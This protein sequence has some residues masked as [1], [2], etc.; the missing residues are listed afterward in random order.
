[1]SPIPRYPS[2]SALT[3]PA[4][5]GVRHLAS[6]QPSSEKSPFCRRASK[7]TPGWLPVARRASPRSVF[8]FFVF[9]LFVFLPASVF[10]Q[11]AQ[12]ASI[13]PT[14]LAPG[15]QVTLTGS[16]FGA[17]QES[18][19]VELQNLDRVPV[20]SWS[21]T[22]IVV[23]VP[24]GT[25]SGGV[26]VSQNGT[27]SNGLPFSMIPAKLAAISPANLA[28]G[29]LAT[30]TGSGFGAAQGSGFVELQNLDRVPVVT[31]SDTRIA[32]TVP[33]GT[34]SGKAYV[35]QNGTW[36]N[37]IFFAMIPANITS[38]S[39][40]TL[41]PGSQATLTGSGFGSAQESGF[42]E[43]QNLDRVPVISWSDTR[44]VVTVPAG[45]ISGRAFVNQD[46]T[47]SNGA[48]FTIDDATSGTLSASAV[49][50]GDVQV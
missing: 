22:Q 30:L 36:S 16:G 17:T 14:N 44:I 1:M 8:G 11:A 38:I 2:V 32:V 46:E 28:P 24:P 45:T 5:D 40:T 50:F 10:A 21:D 35:S 42:V 20:V 26:Y 6:F 19:F 49:N 47:W 29:T 23:T 31:W 15:M 39:P 3:P 33:A 48:A 13:S 4:P 25:I 27:W 18:G 34:I 12:M 41:T 43:L 7:I 9:C 37:G